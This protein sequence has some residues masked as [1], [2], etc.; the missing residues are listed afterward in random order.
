MS[1]VDLQRE[2]LGLPESVLLKD[3]PKHL[4]NMIKKSIGTSMVNQEV[5]VL[6]TVETQDLRL[7][8]SGKV[9]KEMP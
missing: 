1:L 7:Q 2:Q 6:G 4:T 9:I 3:M 5:V 8:V